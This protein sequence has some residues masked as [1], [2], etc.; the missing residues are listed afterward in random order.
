MIPP[1]TQITREWLRAKLDE[2]WG[3]RSELARNTSL[4]SEKISH[5]LAGRRRISVEEQEEIRRFFGVENEELTEE[6]KRLLSAWRRL[7]P[8]IRLAIQTLAET[9]AKAD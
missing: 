1:M 4:S 9:K 6:E 5:I 3:M 8:D 2:K 7:P